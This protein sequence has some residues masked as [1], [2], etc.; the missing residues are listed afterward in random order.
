[1]KYK[2][3]FNHWKFLNKNNTYLNFFSLNENQFSLIGAFRKVSTDMVEI[4]FRTIP[5]R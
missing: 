5:K 3:I 2:E 1:M 4:L